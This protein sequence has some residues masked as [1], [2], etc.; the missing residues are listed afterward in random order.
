M[1]ELIVLVAFEFITIMIILC[2]FD[3]YWEWSIIKSLNVRPHMG[4]FYA[5][6]FLEIILVIMFISLFIY[7]YQ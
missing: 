7:V 3:I 1:Y 2:G 4:E 6:V 5:K